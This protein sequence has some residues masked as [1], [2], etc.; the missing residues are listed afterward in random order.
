MNKIILKTVTTVV[1]VGTLSTA[2]VADEPQFGLG[3]GVAGQ[4]SA[5]LRGTISL[6]DNMRV[7]PYFGFS[8]QDKNPSNGNS[9]TTLDVGSALHM[10]QPI[11]SVLTAYY[12]GFAGIHNYDYGTGNNSGTIFNFGPVAGVEYA[13]DKQFTLGAEMRFNLGFGDETAIGTESSVLLRYYF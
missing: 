10:M 1:L 11:N 3:V 12:G 6:E 5:T 8:Y 13:L 4:N 2:A 7:E 9:E